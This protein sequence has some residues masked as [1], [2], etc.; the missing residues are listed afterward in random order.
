MKRHLL[1]LAVFICIAVTGA[2]AQDGA[3]DLKWAKSLLEHGDY[4]YA[5][6][7]FAD[8]AASHYNSP[9]VRKEALYYVGYCH[10]KNSDPWQ[11]IR[12]F[13][14]FIEKYDNG[15]S[16]DFVPDALYVLGRVYE[17]TGDKRS[18]IKVYR[19]C[20]R[21]YPRSQ[22]AIKSE[23]RLRQLGGSDN[24]DPFDGDYSGD[25]NY[26]PNPDDDYGND[27]HH[28]GNSTGISREIRRLLRV[29]ETVNNDFTRDQMLLEGSDRARSGEDFVALANAIKNTFT[30][31]Q[32]LDRVSKNE[33]YN[34]FS[35][36]SML[37]LAALISN[38]YQ[39]DMF[40]V[41]FGSAMANRDYVSNYELVEVSAAMNN[42]SLRQQLFDAISA[43]KAFQ[44][45][46]ARTMVELAQTCDNSFI[47]DQF[48]LKAAQ[49]NKY[50][51]RD[52]RILADACKNSF[53]KTQIM[54]EADSGHHS[55]YG[56]RTAA[57]APELGSERA[58]SSDPFAGFSFNK[59]QIARI[60]SFM[61][62]VDTKKKMA[63][64]ARQLKSSDLKTA[65]VREYMEKYKV[66][67]KFER[68]HQR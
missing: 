24:T 44:F 56:R 50:G 58:L 8:I 49:K 4:A 29:A 25:D 48:L 16:S 60:R 14:Q 20:S 47:H 43:S 19:R 45:I 40:L 36:R 55:P 32:L 3:K 11:A 37:D 63:E 34:N 62:A 6:E 64:S 46:N 33:N 51:Y 17:E 52:L 68:I 21:A 66:L 54:Q 27:H 9:A 53:T 10:V 18:A 35:T 13:E 65:T 67:Q 41:S 61:K 23:D 31:G 39:R 15:S 1:L 42:D 38:S 2:F 5:A 12:V 59:A 57:I 30:R 26:Y 7:K 22:F 28:P